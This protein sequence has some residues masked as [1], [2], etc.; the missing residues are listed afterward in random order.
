MGSGL[1]GGHY[2]GTAGYNAEVRRLIETLPRNPDKL[3]SHGWKEI[4]RSEKQSNTTSRD[5][6]E[7]K[8][9]LKVLFDKGDPSAKGF[10]AKNH[11]HVRNPE[12]NKK[13]EYYLDKDGNPVPKNSKKSHLFPTK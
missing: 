3:L 10:K 6:I 7:P 5:F 11:Y 2:K 8:T 13:G 9:G 12:S 4:T 1:G